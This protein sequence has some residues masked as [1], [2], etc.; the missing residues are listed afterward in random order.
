MTLISDHGLPVKCIDEGQ[1]VKC[2]V[3][4]AHTKRT[5]LSMNAQLSRTGTESFIKRVCVCVCVCVCAGTPAN[6]K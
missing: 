6:K 5:L 3:E 1:E 2:L 4:Y